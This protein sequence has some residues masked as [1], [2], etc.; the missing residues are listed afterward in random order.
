MIGGWFCDIDKI[1][2]KIAQYS[3]ERNQNLQKMETIAT[4]CN[5]TVLE[6]DKES[7][8]IEDIFQFLDYM[9]ISRDKFPFRQS[10]LDRDGLSELKKKQDSIR[11]ENT[12]VIEEIEMYQRYLAYIEIIKKSWGS[13]LNNR[14]KTKRYISDYEFL[15]DL[16]ILSISADK[17]INGRVISE[18]TSYV[19]I[20]NLFTVENMKKSGHPL[21]DKALDDGKAELISAICRVSWEYYYLSSLADRINELAELK[22]RSMI[23]E[24]KKTEK[25]NPII[26]AW[27]KDIQT[28]SKSQHKDNAFYR[29]YEDALPDSEIEKVNYFISKI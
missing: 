11:D 23:R 26:L 5:N 13:M 25:N 17:N 10:E 22:Y 24:I 14:E 16:Y 1:K 4:N 19:D 15:E 2:A 7:R 28:I 20:I 8:M 6:H 3:S 18:Y 29:Y 9:G 27:K 21:N 12:S